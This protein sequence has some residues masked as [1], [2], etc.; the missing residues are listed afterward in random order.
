MAVS[1]ILARAAVTKYHRLGG[2]NNRNLLSHSS[3]GWKS[4]IRVSAWSSSGENAVPG[5]QTSAFSLCPHMVE[6]SAFP[7]PVLVRTPVLWDQGST[8]KTSF[9]PNNLLKGPVSNTATWEVTA[10]TYALEGDNP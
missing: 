4:E 8:L 9:N 1:S 7:L 10:S 6:N 2:L 3:G 5:W